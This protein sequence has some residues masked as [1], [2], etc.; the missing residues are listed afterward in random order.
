MKT[1]LSTLEFATVQAEV[2]KSF[3]SGNEALQALQQ[4]LSLEDAQRIMED[5]VEGIAYADELSEIVARSLTDDDHAEMEAELA[6][7]VGTSEG[8]SEPVLVMPEVPR[9]PIMPQVP[10]TAPEPSAE[11]R[12]AAMAV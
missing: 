9:V 1:L 8:S 10:V 3:E 12:V 2:I 6:A 11:S 7:L 5:S 4:Q